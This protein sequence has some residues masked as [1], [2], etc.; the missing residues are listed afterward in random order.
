MVDSIPFNRPCLAGNETDY[1]RDAVLSGHTSSG[2]P[3][4]RR[5]EQTLQEWH[6]AEQV[7]LTTSCTD[8]LEMSAMLLGLGPGDSVIVPSFTFTSTALAFARAGASLRFCDIDPI[9]LGLD[10]ARVEELI[11]PDVKAIVTVH[12]A[13]VPSAVDDLAEL[14]ERHSIALIEDN[15]HGLLATDRGRVLG[16]FG[17]MSTLSFHETKN[18]T[19]GEG[20]ALVLNDKRDV[21]AAHILLDKGTNRRQFLDGAV[22][23]Y[24]W[25]GI[26]SSFGMS[27]LL[28]AFLVGQLE[29]AEKIQS[30]RRAVA[31][32][33]RRLLE[34]YVE[35]LAIRLPHEPAEAT[36][37]DHMFYVLLDSAEQRPGVIAEMKRHA[38]HPTFHYVPLHSSPAGREFSEGVADCPVTDDISARLLRLPFY[39]DLTTA[40]I[41]RVV[42]VF[43]AAARQSG[44]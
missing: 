31:V 20:G 13:G 3:Y 4:T 19:C 23:K 17:R 18:F 36:P 25:Q 14:A 6:G 40:Q 44:S 7:L 16:S 5:A 42:E 39:N 30:A 33:Y 26:G 12:Y 9:T 43:V 11:G 22:D 8:A 10:P 28:A 38:V 37:A 34:P 24:T 35:E 2:G 21:D 27:D 29:Q 32:N 1:M 41:E 15:A